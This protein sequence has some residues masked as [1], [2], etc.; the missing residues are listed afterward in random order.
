M[1]VQLRLSTGVPYMISEMEVYLF[2]KVVSFYLVLQEW[3]CK[4]LDMTG[5]LNNNIQNFRL[6][7]KTKKKEIQNSPN[8]KAGNWNS[9]SLRFY[10]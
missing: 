3:G 2:L 9:S 10:S 6:L 7:L 4:E 5:Q 1:R 8:N